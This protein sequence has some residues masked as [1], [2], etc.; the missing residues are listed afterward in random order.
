M[1]AKILVFP[2]VASDGDRRAA[3]ERHHGLCLVLDGNNIK[4]VPTH[5]PAKRTAQPT[6]NHTGPEAA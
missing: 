6:Q 2:A 3:F 4:A 5:M 1:S